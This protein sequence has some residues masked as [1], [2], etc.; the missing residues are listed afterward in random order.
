M[1]QA[2]IPDRFAALIGRYAEISAPLTPKTRFVEDLGADSLG[3]PEIVLAFEDEFGVRVPDEE[4]EQI[5]TVGD[6]LPYLKNTG[7]GGIKNSP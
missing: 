4:L 7:V 5:L 1:S 3:L 2:A 6:L